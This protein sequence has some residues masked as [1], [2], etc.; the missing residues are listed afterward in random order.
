[1]KQAY[2]IL[3]KQPKS[4][5]NAED[6]NHSDYGKIFQCPECGA[7]V[8]LRSGYYKGEVWISPAFVHPADSAPDCKLRID[9]YIR[10]RSEDEIFKF[11]KQGQSSQK[12]EK[13]FMTFLKSCLDRQIGILVPYSI[14]Y[15]GYSEFH[16]GPEEEL[17]RYIQY[18]KFANPVHREPDLFISACVC[19]LRCK[20]NQKYFFDAIK[21]FQSKLLQ[22]RQDLERY[23]RQTPKMQLTPEELA[24]GHCRRLEGIIRFLCVGSSDEFRRDFL[25]LA[26]FADRINLFADPKFIYRNSKPSVFG[27]IPKHSNADSLRRK[28]IAFVRSF[29][30]R[31]L[32]QIQEDPVYVQKAFQNFYQDI[33]EPVTDLIEFVLNKTFLSIRKYDWQTI[34]YYYNRL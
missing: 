4:L 14:L 21:G 26:I 13:A 19:L 16:I 23:L 34:S 1:M 7:T 33:K 27:Q 8:T 12:L 25:E 5:V 18:N 11:L 24:I 20:Y 31:L 32:N 2:L 17:K 22:D 29:D 3:D 28:R 30:H 10:P 6:V 15:S 9:F